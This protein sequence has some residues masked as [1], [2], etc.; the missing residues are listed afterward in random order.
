MYSGLYNFLSIYLWK[1]SN[2]FIKTTCSCYRYKCS[3]LWTVYGQLNMHYILI[4]VVVHVK[5]VWIFSCNALLLVNLLQMMIAESK[6]MACYLQNINVHICK[7]FCIEKG[8]T[9][10]KFLFTMYLCAYF[11]LINVFNFKLVVVCNGFLK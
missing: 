2:L 4:Y 7:L 3:I 5:I 8:N 10:F 9:L 11:V 6:Q 1:S